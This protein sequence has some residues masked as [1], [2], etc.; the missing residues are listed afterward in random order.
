M[1]HLV[2]SATP[3]ICL[4]ISDAVFRF[5]TFVPEGHDE[6]IS[7]SVLYFSKIRNLRNHIGAFQISICMSCLSTK[8]ASVLLNLEDRADI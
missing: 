5:H 7:Q 2:W 8:G 6:N 1:F 4:P 3:T